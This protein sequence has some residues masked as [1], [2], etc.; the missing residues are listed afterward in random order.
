MFANHAHSSKVGDSQ[1]HECGSHD[2][3]ECGSHGD[4]ECAGHDEGH[5]CHCGSGCKH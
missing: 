1:G 5:E 2:D 4:H 3:H